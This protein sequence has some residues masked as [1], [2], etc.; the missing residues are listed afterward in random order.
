MLI[1]AAPKTL[2]SLMLF[3]PFQFTSAFCKTTVSCGKS[4]SRVC[5]NG[6]ILETS[7]GII[8]WTLATAVKL[9]STLRKWWDTICWNCSTTFCRV[10][11][12][13]VF[14]V[15]SRSPDGE[16]SWSLSLTSQ[17]YAWQLLNNFP[18]TFY[19]CN[20]DI[21]CMNVFGYL[22]YSVDEMQITQ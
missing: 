9:G 4:V 1:L 2:H 22:L 20:R 14:Q 5:N 13:A 11:L 6:F 15:S 8:W 7:I 16:T 18:T 17:I 19:S 3:M 21:S 12:K 10:R